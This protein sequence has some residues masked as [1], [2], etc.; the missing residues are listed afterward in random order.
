M[1]TP[2]TEII[3]IILNYNAVTKYVDKFNGHLSRGSEQQYNQG[4]F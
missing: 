2:C 3:M 1:N 4:R